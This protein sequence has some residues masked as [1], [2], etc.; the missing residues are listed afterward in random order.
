M[1]ISRVDVVTRLPEFSDIPDG[2]YFDSVI[3]A[4]TRQVSPKK[5]GSLK[6]DGI[7][8]LVGHLLELGK[9][10][11]R[12]GTIQMEKVGDLQRQYAVNQGSSSSL[13]NTSHGAEYLRLLKTLPTRP[14]IC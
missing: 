11:G 1:A 13:S 4:A 12:S 9:R 2:A 5:W 6:D 3:S 14:L 7:I 10:N 8:L